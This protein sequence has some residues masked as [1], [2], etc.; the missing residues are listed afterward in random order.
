M[1]GD[2][3]ARLFVIVGLLYVTGCLIGIFTP[4]PDYSSVPVESEDEAA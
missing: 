2:V 3:F 1:W 4:P